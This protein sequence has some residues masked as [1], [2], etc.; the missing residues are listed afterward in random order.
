VLL[1]QRRSVVLTEP[2]T[3]LGVRGRGAR[4]L[5]AAVAAAVAYA[6]WRP[7]RVEIAG[8]SMRPTLE[9]G[10]WAVAVRPRSPRPGD[11]VVLEHP[12]RAGFE[13]VKRVVAAGPDGAVRVRGDDPE[14]STDSRTFGPV[15]SG[16]IR[17]RIVAVYHPWRRARLVR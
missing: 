5:V 17:G 2:T 14:A 10:E 8:G 4:A 11:V 1:A 6:R 13:L 16:S 9:P 12:G 7:F 15:P 3:G